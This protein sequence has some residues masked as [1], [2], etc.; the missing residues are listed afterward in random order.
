[1]WS[2]LSKIFLHH[3]IEAVGKDAGNL[4]CNPS[5]DCSCSTNV[6]TK[7]PTWAVCIQPFF[8]YY[9]MPFVSLFLIPLSVFYLFLCLFTFSFILLSVLYLPI[10]FLSYLLFTHFYPLFCLLFVSLYL[11]L[12]SYN[13][14]CLFS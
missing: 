13:L 2:E 6:V 14:V 8:I 4:P 10:I 7:L 5:C 3:V 12:I 9:N 1:M 11:S